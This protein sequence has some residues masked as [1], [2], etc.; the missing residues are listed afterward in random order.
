IEVLIDVFQGHH[1]C[2][3]IFHRTDMNLRFIQFFLERRIGNVPYCH[4]NHNNERRN[5][6]SEAFNREWLLDKA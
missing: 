2:G 6:V 3:K 4:Y 5:K 1:F